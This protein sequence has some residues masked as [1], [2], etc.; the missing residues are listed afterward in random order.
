YK[1]TIKKNVEN[2]PNFNRKRSHQCIEY[3]L[4]R[5]YSKKQSKYKIQE[6]LENMHTK[7]WDKRRKNPELYK[8]VNTT[9]I[10]YW[11][12]KGYSEDESKNKIK[13]RQRTFTLDKCIEK[14]GY[15]K[16]VDIYNDRNRKWSDKMKEMYINGEYVR[17]GTDFV[18]K[19]ENDF[20][21]YIRE[22]LNLDDN[23]IIRQHILKINRVYNLDFKYGKKI[24]EF[25]GDYLH[26]NPK[27]Y[28]SDYFNKSKQMYASEIWEYDNRKIKDL[29]TKYDVL[30]IWESEYK[31]EPEKIL[32]K[33]KEF[34]NE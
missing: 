30:V 28:E 3:W 5:G 24:I 1:K 26:S 21:S 18:S 12:K 15:E 17:H 32:K 25:F 27:I 31:E 23:K 7:T 9:Q 8:D 2:N 29:E 20:V 11:L 19:I 22:K 16:G 14:Y 4:K 13:E 6:V 33:C 10:G 34:L